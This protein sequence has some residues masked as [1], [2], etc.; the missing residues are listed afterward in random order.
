MKQSRELYQKRINSL[1]K[2]LKEWFDEIDDHVND[3][4]VSI[5]NGVFDKP[6]T[7]FG[8]EHRLYNLRN[9]YW[10]NQHYWE[11][12]IDEYI[13]KAAYFIKDDQELEEE[14]EQI[15]SEKQ[16]NKI[17]RGEYLFDALTPLKVEM[18]LILKQ[19]PNIEEDQFLEKINEI[20]EEKITLGHGDGWDENGRHFIVPMTFKHRILKRMKKKS[21]Y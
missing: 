18:L 8:V 20:S 15:F 9:E 10:H 16:F 2:G 6:D 7:V 3:E 5:I 12:H 17:N 21:S 4:F 19:E 11:A 14:L 1:N 13:S